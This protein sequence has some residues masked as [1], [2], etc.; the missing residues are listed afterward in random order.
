MKDR[1]FGVEVECG[2]GGNSPSSLIR[3][4][5]G[6]RA[7]ERQGKLSREW[8]ENFGHDGTYVEL[9]SPILEGRSG[10]AELRR[11][12]KAISKCGGYVTRSDGMHVHHNAPDYLETP[13]KV[14]QLVRT[15]RNN[16]GL[17]SAFVDPRR[18]NA[19]ACIGWSSSYL[20]RLEGLVKA[21]PTR[22]WDTPERNDLNLRSLRRHGS[23]EIRLHEGCLDPDRA[24]AWVRFGQS[25]L[26][27]VMETD[28][29]FRVDKHE[30][31]LRKIKVSEAAR[32]RLLE[33]ARENGVRD[34]YRTRVAA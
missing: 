7:I 2:V 27:K 19:Y 6:L 30:D 12:L 31:L 11:A 20:T 14:I 8:R 22:V 1:A 34:E 26:N 33:R 15:W 16:R 3:L 24:E 5:D 28:S 25:F 4:W 10:F 18:V 13:E 9:R 17:I 29:P 21:D 23:I 32:R